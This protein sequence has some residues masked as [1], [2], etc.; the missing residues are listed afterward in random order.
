MLIALIGWLGVFFLTLC[1]VPQLI[2]TWKV[3][4]VRGLSL[5]ML[6]Y[7]WIGLVLMFVYI[8]C[9]STEWILLFNYG[10]NT[11][12]VGIILIGYYKARKSQIK[13]NKAEI[14][15]VK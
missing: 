8:A 4:E 15:R 11:F 5:G 3:K 1:S 9:T 13:P 10:F 6:W 2:L 7:W 14:K 12:L